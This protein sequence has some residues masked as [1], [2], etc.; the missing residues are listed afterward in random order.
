[1]KLLP[2]EFEINLKDVTYYLEQ[3]YYL[4]SSECTESKVMI[5]SLNNI[6]K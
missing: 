5:I 2:V 4:C 1:M 3:K 6:G